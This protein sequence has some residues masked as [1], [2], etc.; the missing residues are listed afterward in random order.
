[1]KKWI[2]CGM[3]LGECEE[4]KNT[5]R[6]NESRLGVYSRK[7]L[8]YECYCN[9]L[10]K[11]DDR[12]IEKF[13]KIFKKRCGKH[14]SKYINV[15]SWTCSRGDMRDVRVAAFGIE[16]YLTV[17]E[18]RLVQKQ[19]NLN[20]FIDDIIERVCKLMN[21]QLRG[22][23]WEDVFTPGKGDGTGCHY[24]LTSRQFKNL[25]RRLKSLKS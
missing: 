14:L 25:I 21:E 5:I 23:D 24:V 6:V 7:D 22:A 9:D 10:E 12:E 16:I 19:K 1:V 20:G 11:G 15:T 2:Q 17:Q 13:T 8:C 3:K 18:V 4:C